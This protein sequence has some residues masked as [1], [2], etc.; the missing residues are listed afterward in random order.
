MCVARLRRDLELARSANPHSAAA[1]DWESV[2][3]LMQNIR[4][5]KD[6]LALDLSAAA[7]EY[8]VAP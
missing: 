3:A 6:Q 2:R 5:C 7:L 8:K 1:F 4:K